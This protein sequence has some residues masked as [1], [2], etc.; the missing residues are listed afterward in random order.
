[1]FDVP[2]TKPAGSITG[3]DNVPWHALTGRQRHLAVGNDRAVR[4]APAVAPLRRWLTPRLNRSTSW[5]A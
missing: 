1:M 4:Y 5:R 2:A 3:L